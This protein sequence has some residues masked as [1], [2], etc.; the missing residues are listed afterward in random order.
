M[1]K[2]L[3]Y[4]ILISVVIAGCMVRMLEVNTRSLEYDEIEDYL[5]ASGIEDGFMQELSSA[6]EE[7]I[8]P[9]NLGEEL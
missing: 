9:F 7:Y 1:N 2:K 8:P 4:I 6:K 5:F 3:L